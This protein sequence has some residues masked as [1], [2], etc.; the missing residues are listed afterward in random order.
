MLATLKR[1]QIPPDGVL[2][3][4]RERLTAVEEII[5]REDLITL[6]ERDLD[7][8]EV[9]FRLDSFSFTSNNISYALY[10]DRLKYWNFFPSGSHGWAGAK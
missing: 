3:L 4:Y 2:D 1:E 5:R 9:R 8:G 7:D 6:P 10:G